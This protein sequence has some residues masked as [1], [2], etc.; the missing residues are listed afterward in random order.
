MSRPFVK[1]AGA[2][3]ADGVGWY[4]KLPASGDFVHRRLPRELIAWWDRWL[5][6]GL[7]A[8]RAALDESEAQRA[9]AAA[10][11]WNFAIPA[12]LG[13]GVVQL[14]CIGASRDRVGRRYPLC[15]VSYLHPDDYDARILENA[16]DYYR[17]LG[18]GVLG[19][20]RHGRGAEQLD[21]MLTQPGLSLA[22]LG[23]PD[24][25]SPGSDIMDI[26]NAGIAR[27]PEPARGVAW[28]GLP[29]Y[30][31]PGSHTSYWWTNQADG[32]ALLTYVHGGALNATLFG[33]LFLPLGGGRRA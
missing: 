20:V 17:Q 2:A 19:A 30:F 32:A 4:G 5:Q 26:L 13:A 11:I 9:Y 14:G 12:G 22:S 25:A 7:A 29:A 1:T 27:E 15:L 18:T 16:G 10:P 21:Q 24:A 28:T 33:K 23:R 3:G 8:L 6:H 31:N